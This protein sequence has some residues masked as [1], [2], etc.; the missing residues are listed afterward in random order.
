MLLNPNINENNLFDFFKTDKNSCYIRDLR[1]PS[2]KRYTKRNLLW[3]YL[4]QYSFKLYKSGVETKA[5]FPSKEEALER[6]AKHGINVQIT[7][8]EQLCSILYSISIARPRTTI[9]SIFAMFKRNK[10]NY[11]LVWAFSDVLLIPDSV[12]SAFCNYC[13]AFAALDLFVEIAIPTALILSAN[14]IVT[15]RTSGLSSIA[16]EYKI[17]DNIEKLYNFDLNKLIENFPDNQLYIHP[18]KLSKWK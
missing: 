6:F 8:W 12:M 18:V 16:N 10:V 13:G 7:L 15:D 2:E 5:I 1:V 9:R 11:P 4:M 17:I 3:V 14:K